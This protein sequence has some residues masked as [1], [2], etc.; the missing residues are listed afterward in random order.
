MAHG[1]YNLQGKFI[2]TSSKAEATD[3]WR[4]ERGYSTGGVYDVGGGEVVDT[5]RAAAKRT[6]A[7]DPMIA[8]RGR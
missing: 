1:Y 6:A 7:V 4:K 3:A 5:R 8:F 2:T